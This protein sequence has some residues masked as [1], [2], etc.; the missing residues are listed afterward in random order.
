M[1]ALKSRLNGSSSVAAISTIPPVLKY[2]G[3]KTRIS[4][5]ILS[6]MPPHESYV[7]PFFGSG[8]VFFNKPKARVE[9]INDMDNDV[10]NFFRICRD[11]P[12]ELAE[13]LRLTPW[14]RE[15]REGSYE[16]TEDEFERARRF[17]VKC[18]QT[19]GSFRDRNRGWRHSTGKTSNG[20][21]DNPKLWARL[22]RAVVEVSER[23]LTAQIENRPALD[24]IE[25]YNG[26]GVLIY[27]D[28]PYLHDTRTANGYAYRHEMSTADHEMLLAALRVHRGMVLLSGYDHE[29][30]N[31]VLR[32]WFKRTLDTTAER[33]V[34]RTE[35]LWINPA[36]EAKINVDQLRLF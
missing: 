22:P 29:L 15:E 16:H 21:P 17:A 11:R 36:G 14:A 2:P 27:A 9:T 26:A 5:W 34:Q 12:N 30:Y 10:V 28:P 24:V 13:A 33:G 6:F 23:L 35:C 8:G 18:W 31:D 32:G 25:R 1:N 7:E 3:S 4:S 19:F 20:G